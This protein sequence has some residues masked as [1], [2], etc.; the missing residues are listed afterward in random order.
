MSTNTGSR[1]WRH[2]YCDALMGRPRKNPYQKWWPSRRYL[3]G[4]NYGESQVW[5]LGIKSLAA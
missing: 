3:S 1:A 5:R 4:Y 2:G